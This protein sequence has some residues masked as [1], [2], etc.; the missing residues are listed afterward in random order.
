MLRQ[1]I[2]MNHETMTDK[3]S[4]QSNSWGRL[5]GYLGYGKRRIDIS[6]Q[7]QFHSAWIAMALIITLLGLMTRIP[8]LMAIAAILITIVI[9]SSVWNRL[10]FVGVNYERSFSE[11]RAFMGETIE[12][13]I[14]VANHKFLPLTWLTTADVFPKALPVEE[15]AI[16]IRGDTGKGELQNFWAL[17]WYDQSTRTYHL[18][19]A[20]RGFH[21]FGPVELQTGDGFGMF[22]SRRRVEMIHTLVVYPRIIPITQLGLPA[23]DP[24][25]D[26][27]ANQFMF[28]D[29]LRTVGIRDYRHEDDFRKVHWKASARR[30]QLQTRVLEPSNDM[31]LMVCLNVATVDKSWLGFIPNHL[32]SM[33]SVAASVTYDALMRRWPVGLLA[34]GTLP[35]SDQSIKILPGRSAMQLTTILELLAA[36][37]P[38]T[39]APFET[40]LAEES[41][42]LPWGSTL[43]LL[44]ASVSEN[45]TALLLKLNATGRKLVLIT[46]DKR[47]LPT[48]LSGIIVYRIDEKRLHA[49]DLGHPQFG[50]EQLLTP[51]QR[52]GQAISQLKHK[53]LAL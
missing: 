20:T 51:E 17:K 49:I 41:A 3:P 43:V 29:P 6:I 7:E 28:E 1:E 37:T 4:E 31:N 5:K 40:L 33:I 44:S 45:L 26:R 16:P 23:K 2:I 36:I 42:R 8:E 38:F 30:Q 21:T 34:N 32:E 15:V 12:L 13:K 48:Q 46:L 9:A 53:K 14:S 39:S 35:G 10:A 18:H 22:R 24:Y 47:P 52:Q 11:K 50:A 25:G 19:A 27:A